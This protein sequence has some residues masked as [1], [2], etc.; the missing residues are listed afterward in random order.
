MAIKSLNI[1]LSENERKAIQ[2]KIGPTLH[3]NHF[4]ETFGPSSILKPLYK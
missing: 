3:W 1:S 2:Q 4:E